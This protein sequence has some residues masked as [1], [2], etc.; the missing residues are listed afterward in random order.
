MN[1]FSQNT[2]N[3]SKALQLPTGAAPPLVSE[4]ADGYWQGLQQG[5]LMVQRCSGC[6]QLRHYP[7]PM[8]PACHSLACSWVA[9][10]GA[11][12]LHSWT[13]LHQSGL[14]PSGLAEVHT[15]L[16]WTLLT[17]DMAEGVRLLGLLQGER[18]AELR[19]GLTL[20]A[21]VGMGVTGVLQPVF[22]LA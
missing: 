9:L 7:R 19:P 22:R 8:C 21:G 10:G 3:A 11:G 14:G 17:V 2:P 5:R 4:F 12:Q 6:G 15:D 18:P 16:P 13:V 1:T 20:R